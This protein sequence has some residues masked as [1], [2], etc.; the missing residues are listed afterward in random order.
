MK[1]KI[2][3]L[4]TLLVLTAV[5]ETIT[6]ALKISPVLAQSPA[7]GTLP[8]P[9]ASSGTTVKIDGS[10]SMSGT[11][12]ALKQRFEK[13]SPGQEVN[14]GYEGTDA[15][16]QSVLDGKTDLAAVGRPLTAEEKAKELVVV[17]QKR[18]KI[19]IVVGSENPFTGNL[20]FKQFAKIFRGEITN[21]S[22][23]GGP[24]G[25]IQVIDRPEA[26]DTRQA[27]QNYPVFKQAPFKAAANAV[28]LPQDDSEAMIKE[29][30]TRGIGYAI[31]EQVTNKSGVRIVP[32]H[33][34]LP[35]DPRYPFSQPLAYVYKGP[36]PSPA[37]RAFLGYAAAPTA[38][39]A[40][41]A[42]TASPQTAVVP[43]SVATETDTEGVPWLWLLLIPLLGGLG[44]LFWWL[45]KNR[46]SEAAI[47]AIAHTEAVPMAPA[48]AATAA[49]VI[50]NGHEPQN[51]KLYEERLVANKTRQKTG[52]VAVGKRV[53][54]E[55][56][57]VSVPIEKERV[58]IERTTPTDSGTAVA[59]S[60]ADFHDGEVARMN[61]YEETPD[62]YK[63]AFV[64][65]EVEVKKVVE[66]E[67][68]E[69]QETLRREELDIDTEYRTV[70]DSKNG[71]RNNRI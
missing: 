70:E 55:L 69:A 43:P 29:L 35:T 56:A 66:Q 30:G 37:V 19:A 26:S 62:I 11:N 1:P 17:P 48:G 6:A 22:E 15:A 2:T 18:H 36:E 13:Q 68:I 8:A 3:L 16:L 52:D 45:L 57:Q 67:T 7:P 20:T 9:V 58:V 50:L 14:I 34:T 61:I 51:I 44:G 54:T 46:G 60:D 24:P 64:R 49:P 38:S 31:A 42:A 23:V 63:E 27:F 39:V 28:Q 33:K 53:E 10:S 40:A 12:Q 5:P 4:A 41:P 59:P 65:E 25:A 71:H 32:M 21:W 47:G